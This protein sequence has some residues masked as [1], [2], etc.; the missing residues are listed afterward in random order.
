MRYNKSLPSPD[1]DF[2][3]QQFSPKK[4]EG[5]RPKTVLFAGFLIAIITKNSGLCKEK[6][7]SDRK[8]QWESRAAASPRFAPLF[9]GQRPSSLPAGG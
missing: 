9:I 2:P 1:G 8:M 6:S 5:N 3:F 4:S 7:L